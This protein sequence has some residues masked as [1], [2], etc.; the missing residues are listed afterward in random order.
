MEKLD[1]RI[2]NHDKDIERT[3]NCHYQGFVDCIHELLKVRPQAAALKQEI[4][5]V[6]SDLKNSAENIVR[7]AEDLIKLRRVLCNTKI[8][9]E[10]LQECLPVLETFQRLMNQMAEKKYYPALKTLEQFETLYWP[11]F[12]KYRFAQSMCKELPKIR[13]TIETESGKDLKDFL[14][15][16]RKSTSRIGE[17]ALRNTAVSHQSTDYVKTLLNYDSSWLE[18]SSSN[19]IGQGENGDNQIGI[20]ADKLSVS[21]I[22]DFAPVYRC[23]HI[24]GCLG[25]RPQFEHYY[26]VQRRKQAKLIFQFNAHNASLFTGDGFSKYLFSVVGFF[27]IEDHLLSKSNGLVTK[28][29]LVE[30]WDEVIKSLVKNVNE[31]IDECKDSQQMIY[32]KSLL[33]VFCHTVQSYGYCTD[34]IIKLLGDLRQKYIDI[35]QDNWKEKFEDIFNSDNYHPLIVEDEQQFE[36]IFTG[37]PLMELQSLKNDKEFNADNDKIE[38]PKKFPFSSM[39][40]NIYKAVREFIVKAIQFSND[41]NVTLTDT[42]DMVRSSTNLLLTK[43]L[44]DSLQTLIKKSNLGLLELIQMSNNLNYLGEAST[45]LKTHINEQ[46]TQYCSDSGT[47]SKVGMVEN[48]LQNSDRTL[49]S[50]LNTSSGSKF[51]DR[52]G[53]AS[54]EPLSHTYLT[55]LKGETMFGKARADAESQIY[56]QLHKKILDFF[57]IAEYDFMMTELTGKAS[58]YILDLIAFLRTTFQAFT[59]LPPRVAQTACLLSSQFISARMLKILK[60]DD[61]KAFSQVFLDQFD[62]DLVQCEMYADSEPVPNYN[63]GSLLECFSELRQIMDLLTTDSNWSTYFADYGKNESKYLKVSPQT[64]LLLLEKQQKGEAKK[65]VFSTLSKNERDK[66]N[67]N[68]M[69]V[70]K[71]KEIIANN[72]SA[73]Q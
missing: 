8:A 65:G 3:C 26:R 13:E 34:E 68:E 10:H 18:K 60:G 39:V 2:K 72:N 50:S 9:I 56:H 62:L 52:N 20:G 28:Q 32:L 41:L 59:N 23:L 38:Y 58:P 46:I 63:D 40:T 70:K 12:K 71:L 6:N 45:Y 47:P 48:D 22:V 73:N 27:V 33:M 53:I 29:Y 7:K 17:I 4:N 54:S 61:S 43:T 35:L 57:E 1:A 49:D 44:S 37:F 15:N 25:T 67:R 24:F 36:E 66:K 55:E 5:Q 69:I 16:I 31:H 30:N 51:M 21:E 42:E 11:K 19:S 14:E 64:A